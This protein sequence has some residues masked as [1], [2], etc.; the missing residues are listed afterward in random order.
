MVC[1]EIKL[2]DSMLGGTGQWT[3][4]RPACTFPAALAAVSGS[5]LSALATNS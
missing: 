4:G 3:N 5:T 2:G 1:P